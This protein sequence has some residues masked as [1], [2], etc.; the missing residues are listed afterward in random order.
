MSSY[1]KHIEIIILSDRDE[2]V[3][4]REKYIYFSMDQL[5]NDKSKENNHKE[6]I[7]KGLN[8]VCLVLVGVFALGGLANFGR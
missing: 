8:K 2:A 3:S 4:I 5:K 7:Q 1:G 6:D